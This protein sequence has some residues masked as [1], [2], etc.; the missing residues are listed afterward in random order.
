LMSLN[1]VEWS[2]CRPFSL[3]RCVR[4]HALNALLSDSQT[5]SGKVSDGTVFLKKKKK[6]KKTLTRL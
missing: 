5:R 4:L 3:A 6:K 1:V 2:A